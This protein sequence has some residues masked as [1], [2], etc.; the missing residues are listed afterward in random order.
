MAVPGAS[1]CSFWSVAQSRLLREGNAD[2]V[3]WTQM[4][5]TLDASLR[6]FAYVRQRPQERTA[7]QQV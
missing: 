3:D 2:N 1:A 4:V 5:D 7:P 6:D